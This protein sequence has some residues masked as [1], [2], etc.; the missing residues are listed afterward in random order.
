VT[1]PSEGNDWIEL[2]NNSDQEI[3]MEGITIYDGGGVSKGYIFTAGTKIAARALMVIE[4]FKENTAGPTFGLSSGGDEVVLIDKD[5]KEIDNVSVPALATDQSYA[6]IGNGGAGWQIV[7]VPTKG[8]DNSATAEVALKGKIVINEVYTFSNQ[9][10]V[11]DLDWIELYNT[12]EEEIDL[13][14]LL[15][16]EG[17]GR[18]EAWP[19]P[20]GQKIAAKSYLLIECDKY[21]LHA[22]TTKYPTWGLSKGP[23]EYVVLATADFAQLDSIK[24]PSLN[25]NESYGRKTDGASDWQI[26]AQYTKGTTNVGDARAEHVNTVGVYINEVYTDN[27]SNT[28]I[29]NW[30]ATV[31]FIELY[32]STDVAI[33]M[34]GWEIYDDTAD[35]SKKYVVPNG[36]I[37]PAKGYLTYDVFKDNTAGPVFGLGVSGDWVFVFTK[38]GRDESNL[39]DKMEI[40]GL[41]KNATPQQR[42]MGYTYGR[43]EDASSNLTFFK[44]ASKGASNNGKEIITFE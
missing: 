6:R 40:P 36:T 24:C 44:E 7:D 34:S 43:V 29:T 18:E 30:D 14:G 37:I 27:S 21:E 26:F 16:W 4:T 12:T 10:A 19:I 20:A 41:T 42:D 9:S 28:S 38:A 23:D 22:N 31:D 11:E 25:T 33:D 17:G 5:S 35:D 32:N 15:L 13:S 3:D 39:V 8:T 1:S 2:Y